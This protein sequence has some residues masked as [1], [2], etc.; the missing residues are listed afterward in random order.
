MQSDGTTLMAFS[1]CSVVYLAE[2]A[3]A[4]AEQTVEQ[5]VK[6]L[7]ILLFLSHKNQEADHKLQ[8]LQQLVAERLHS[9]TGQSSTEKVRVRNTEMFI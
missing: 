2:A 9:R 6:R 7:K 3:E 8:A 1:S 5:L 4:C